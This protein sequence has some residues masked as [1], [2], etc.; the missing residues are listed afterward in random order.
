MT[1]VVISPVSSSPSAAFLCRQVSGEHFSASGTSVMLAWPFAA[2][3]IYILVRM[4]I[5]ILS[6]PRRS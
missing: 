2:V 3:L 5:P 1:T 4:Y 6:E